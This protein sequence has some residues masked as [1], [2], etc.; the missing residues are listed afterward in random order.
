[1]R[2]AGLISLVLSGCVGGFHVEA[3]AI[4]RG[5]PVAGATVSM[6]CPQVVKASAP[7]PL[8]TTDASGGLVMREPAFGRWIHDGCELVVK[9]PGY[10][11]RRFPVENVCLGY[12][13]N[14][15]T[16]AVIVAEL[17]PELGGTRP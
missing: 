3:R 15:C 12:E 9:K 8:G 4:D 13:A 2:R 17:T 16:R 6:D 7:S 10:A 14:H 1:M 11:T 5:T